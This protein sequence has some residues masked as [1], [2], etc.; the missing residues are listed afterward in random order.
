MAQ[1]ALQATIKDGPGPDRFGGVLAQK[2]SIVV[3]GHKADLHALVPVRNPEPPFPRHLPYLRLGV[4]ADRKD[5]A[6]Q[7]LL[8]QHIEDVGL[9]L[10]LIRS[11]TDPPRAVGGGDDAGGF[12]LGEGVDLA[13]DQPGGAGAGDGVDGDAVAAHGL[14]QRG[15][16]AEQAGR[17]EARRLE[18]WLGQGLD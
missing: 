11:P 1:P 17:R 6:P 14:V 10:G 4:G 3:V 5:K 2:A 16:L 12:V 7:L 9:V 18:A 13:F 15:R 8:A